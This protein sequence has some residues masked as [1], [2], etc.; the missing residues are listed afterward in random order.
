MADDELRLN[1]VERFSKQSTRLVLEEHG[2]CEVPAGCGGVVLQWHDPQAGLPVTMQLA[3]SF[4]RGEVSIDGEP[5]QHQRIV[6][7]YGRHQLAIRL[8]DVKAPHWFVFG[9]APR[10]QAD[11]SN[12]VVVPELSSAA[13]GTW[14]A[15]TNDP[16]DAW[17]AADFGDGSW[18][19][20]AAAPSLSDK[21]LGRDGYRYRTATRQGCTVLALPP[22]ATVWVR[23]SIDVRPEE[24]QS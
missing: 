2:H 9:I 14:R 23:A 21:Q 11:P 18:S 16:G 24:E 5:V 8:E 17:Q 22:A 15:T 10:F 13:N 4:G 1:T 6:L 20:L 19:R 12:A 7:P 3:G